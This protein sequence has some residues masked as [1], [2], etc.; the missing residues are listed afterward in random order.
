[1]AGSW[2]STCFAKRRPEIVTRAEGSAPAGFR[3]AMQRPRAAVP[4]STCPC[5]GPTRNADGP[6]PG[7]DLDCRHKDAKLTG[8]DRTG[9][10]RTGA[11]RTGIGGK[12]A[13]VALGRHPGVRLVLASSPEQ[14]GCGSGCDGTGRKTLG[15]PPYRVAT[16]RRSSSL[17]SR[18]L[19]LLRRL[20]CLEGLVRVIRPAKHGFR[21]RNGRAAFG[22][23]SLSA[24]QALRPGPFPAG[25]TRRRS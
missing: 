13:R 6:L 15:H 14:D 1:M 2:T 8:A 23:S 9:L 25:R 16:G 24:R 19:I 10:A 17:P 22:W 7:A 20:A 4:P 11:D 18:I 5:A 12:P 21:A 3:F